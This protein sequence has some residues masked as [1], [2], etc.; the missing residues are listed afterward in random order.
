[1]FYVWKN[2]PKYIFQFLDL[3]YLYRAIRFII[4]QEGGD[5]S[6]LPPAH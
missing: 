2:S 1:M 5:C 6:A 3:Q 4:Y